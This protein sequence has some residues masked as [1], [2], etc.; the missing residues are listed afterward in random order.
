MELFAQTARRG[1]LVLSLIG[2]TVILALVTGGVVAGWR[3]AD[4][5]NYNAA[6]AY[7]LLDPSVSEPGIHQEII[8]FDPLRQKL[9]QYLSGLNISHSF[10]FEYLSNG[11][12]IRDGADQVST[13][14][15]LM[16]TPV[17]MDL[18]K[19]AE[20][21]KLKLDDKVSVK[22]ADINTDNDYGDPTH[23]KAGDKLSLRSAAQITLQDSDN[24]TLNV[25][26]DKILPL[27]NNNTDSI[28]SLDITYSLTGDNPGN[29]QVNIS[30]RSYSSVLKCLYY[31]C[32]LGPNDSS[33]LLNYLSG[34]VEH[35][36]LMAGVGQGIRVAHK[37]GSSAT[38]QS[39]CGIIY[40]PGKPYLICLMFFGQSVDNSNSDGYFQY[41]SRTIYNYLVTLGKD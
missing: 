35:N 28:Q 33:Q 9:K 22:A 7:P 26:K 11:V 12:N 40:Y 29:E 31:A 27:L 19:L 18:Y 21:G 38:T 1:K 20:V 30:A 24:T 25:I 34:S 37:V 16:K 8:N 5:R 10:Y 6:N 36:R 4:K 23:L 13:A 2:I 41:V 14:A 15:S 39:D 32:F 17:V 3:I